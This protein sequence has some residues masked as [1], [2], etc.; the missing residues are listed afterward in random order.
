MKSFVYFALV[1]SLLGASVLAAFPLSSVKRVSNVP[2]IPN[3]FIVEVDTLAAIPNKRA[4]ARTLDAVYDSIKARA[5]EFDV[6]K[7]FESQGL[8]VGASVTINNAADAET[9]ETIPG[10]KAIY[11]VTLFKKPQPVSKH[12]VSGPDDPAAIPSIFSTHVATGVDKVHARGFFGK[13]IKIG[14]IDTGI[15]YTHPLLGGGIGPGKKVIGGYDFVGDAYDGTNDPVPD[16]DPLDCEGH[17]T[18]VAGIIAADPN[19]PYNVTGV[20]Y[21]SSISAYRVFG[22]DGSTTDEVIIE[23]LLKG[24]ADGQDI[25]TLSLGGAD[26]WTASASAV[27]A[28]RIARNGKVVTIAAGNDGSS[29]AWYTSSPG[30]GIDAI[31]VASVENTVLSVQEAIVSGVDHAPIPYFSFRTLPIEGELPIYALTQD[32]TIPNDACAPLPDDTPD[33]SPYLVIVRRG[34]CT[35]VQK[36]ENIKA[37]GAKQAL[38]YD[39]GGGA[40]GVSV[41]GFVVALIGAADG[42]FL[43]EQ[44]FAGVPVKVSF[45]PQR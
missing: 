20:A 34:T 35:F 9:L 42:A 16:D 45:P 4:Y 43:V 3:K 41:P 15:D 31:S 21:Q 11:A 39:N 25:L 17:G 44:F 12:I 24:V 33:L 30:N 40:T 13:G 29:G 38:V 36:M 27:V 2:T 22:C 28:S 23:S 7:E 6:N 10:V 26:G 37:K 19:N 14:I 1:H 8:F 18:H 5:V 32:T